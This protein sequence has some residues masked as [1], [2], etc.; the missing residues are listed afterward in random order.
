MPF[1]ADGPPIRTEQTLQ[2][3]PVHE[4]QGVA[5][6]AA[7]QL[8]F[9]PEAALAA[10]TSGCN[11]AAVSGAASVADAEAVSVG[12]ED[13][14]SPV[15]KSGVVCGCSTGC[16]VSEAG[17]CSTEGAAALGGVSGDTGADTDVVSGACRPA[18]VTAGMSAKLASGPSADDH[19]TCRPARFGCQRPGSDGV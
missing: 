3:R 6:E 9:Q 12:A 1:N 10:E 15:P 7:R 8:G 11:V 2:A 18:C 13:W 17:P 5:A 14:L 4:P 19:D 16:G